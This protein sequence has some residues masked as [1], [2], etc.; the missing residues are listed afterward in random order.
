MNFGHWVWG[1]RVSTVEEHLQMAAQRLDQL[2]LGEFV[3]VMW[4]IWNERNRLVF[5]NSSRGRHKNAAARAV[6]FVRGY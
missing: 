3:A 2:Q 1:S 6:Q 4:E 5:G